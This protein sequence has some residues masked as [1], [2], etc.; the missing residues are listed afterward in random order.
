MK[1]IQMLSNVD[2]VLRLLMLDSSEIN[3][4]VTMAFKS[5]RKTLLAHHA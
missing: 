2:N 5:R 1:E 4:S 3:N